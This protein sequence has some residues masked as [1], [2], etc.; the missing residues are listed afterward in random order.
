VKNTAYALLAIRI[1]LFYF[2]AAGICERVRAQSETRF[3]LV[4]D[5]II[6]GQVMAKIFL[7]IS[8]KIL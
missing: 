4:R 3:R 2:T 6:V 5:V 8:T 1:A 7:C